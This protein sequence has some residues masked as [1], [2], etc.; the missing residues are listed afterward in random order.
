MGLDIGHKVQVIRRS[1]VHLQVQDH[2]QEC[3][4]REHRMEDS[5]AG[6]GIEIHPEEVVA[7]QEVPIEFG[8]WTGLQSTIA[9][10]SDPIA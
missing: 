9:G 1:H 10:C 6:V 7:A 5:P 4:V 8:Q 3:H 2:I